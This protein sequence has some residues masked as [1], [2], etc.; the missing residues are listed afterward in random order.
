MRGDSVLHLHVQVRQSPH[1][2]LHHLQELH[3]YT[4]R[5]A[6]SAAMPRRSGGVLHQFALT[7]LMGHSCRNWLPELAAEEVVLGT[8]RFRVIRL[9]GEGGYSFVYL[10]REDTGDGGGASQ[11]HEYAL[12]KVCARTTESLRVPGWCPPTV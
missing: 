11:A 2:D 4:A 12:K 8:R 1:L 5:T 6:I 3:V 10:V 7:A 9:L